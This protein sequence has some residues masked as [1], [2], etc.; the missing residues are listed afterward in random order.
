MMKTLH[1]FTAAESI[2]RHWQGALKDHYLLH[3]YADVNTLMNAITDAGEEIVLFHADSS[4]APQEALRTITVSCPGLSVLVLSDVPSFHEG[5]A[6]LSTGIKGYGN[7][8]LHPVALLQALQII[9]GGS[10]WFYPDFMQHL[11]LAVTQRSDAADPNLLVRLSER[12]QEAAIMVADGLQNRQIAQKM[13]IT[14]RTV[15]AHLGAI[16]A[17]LGVKD[18]VG[19]ALLLRGR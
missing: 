10:H 7:A 14:E 3:T 5:E 12:E 2:L 19:L 11:V 16:F 13:G 8:R 4:A 9:E 15:K 17:K 1:L 18:R 6:L